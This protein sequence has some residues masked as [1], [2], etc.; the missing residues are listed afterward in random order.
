MKIKNIFKIISLI[1]ISSLSFQT[2]FAFT[3]LSDTHPNY[4]AITNLEE[5]G[6]IEGYPDGTF[7]ADQT[8]NRVE[9]LKIILLGAGIDTSTANGVAEFTDTDLNAWYMPFINKAVSMK[10]VEGYPD[11]SFKPAQTINL[12]EALKVVQ[13][14]NNIDL[15][16]TVVSGD[17]YADAY[18]N[19]WYSSYVQ[20]A[21]D[22]NL[23]DADEDNN[24][25][26]SQGMTRGKLVELIYRLIILQESE[27][28][29][30]EGPVEESNGIM[31]VTLNVNIKNFSFIQAEMTIGLG[32]TVRWTNKDTTPHTVTSDDDVFNSGN[33]NMEDTFEYTF[34]E[35]GTFSYDCSYH[36]SMLG[37]ITVKPANEVPTI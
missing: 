7:K 8:V 32:S 19:Q 29:V 1:T 22:N 18:A 6:I 27:N 17:P 3:D 10:I 15:A 14:A 23:I 11:G 9:A 5:R 35:I 28:G 31:P 2:A 13:L 26:P 33:M 16:G 24:V 20:Y 30:V 36:P 25:F 37:T 12:V 34:N 4:K 21:K